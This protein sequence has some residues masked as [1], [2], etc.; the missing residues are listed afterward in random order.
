MYAPMYL[1]GRYKDQVRLL[2]GPAG[3]KEASRE[4][5]DG[6]MHVLDELSQFAPWQ[7]SIPGRLAR[8]SPPKLA[9]SIQEHI[10]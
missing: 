6:L 7:Q 9:A 10:G 4:V 3:A 2:L 1:Q 8:L 5:C